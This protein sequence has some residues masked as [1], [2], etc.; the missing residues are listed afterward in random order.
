MNADLTTNNGVVY[1]LIYSDK[2]GSRRNAT[3]PTDLVSEATE[4]VLTVAH[5]DYI[6]SAT[7]APGIRSNMRLQ[8]TQI[9]SATGQKLVTF[10]QLTVGRPTASLN[11]DAVHALVEELL[12]MLAGNGNYTANLGL[13]D[14]VFETREQ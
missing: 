9:E 8:C 13:A 5:Q 14:E 2:D 11:A 7:K 12:S 3:V 10:A 6:D 1:K 4:V